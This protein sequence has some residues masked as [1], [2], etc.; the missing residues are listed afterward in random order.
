MIASLWEWNGQAYS[1]M[2][3]NYVIEYPEGNE[4][5][6]KSHLLM[7]II[8]VYSKSPEKDCFVDCIELF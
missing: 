6:T 7:Q 1:R 5:E 2:A 8:I 4:A 3:N